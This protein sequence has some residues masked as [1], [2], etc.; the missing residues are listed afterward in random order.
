VHLEYSSL[1]FWDY[2]YNNFVSYESK[3]FQQTPLSGVVLKYKYLMPGVLLK[4]KY[5]SALE[6]ILHHSS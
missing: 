3:L 6:F 2:I 5:W 1:S 4:V